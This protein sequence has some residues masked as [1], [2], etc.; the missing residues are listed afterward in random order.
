[1]SRGPSDTKVNGYELFV[2]GQRVRKGGRILFENEFMFTTDFSVPIAWIREM[3]YRATVRVVD[4]WFELGGIIQ[5][6][7]W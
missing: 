7:E 3:N 1:M 4:F 5:L 2:D 6:K